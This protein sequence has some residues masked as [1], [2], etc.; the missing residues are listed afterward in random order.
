MPYN[1]NVFQD[2]IYF[3]SF[4]DCSLQL[5]C[6]TSKHATIS[7]VEPST[8]M[9]ESAVSIDHGTPSLIVN[10]KDIRALPKEGKRKTEEKTGNH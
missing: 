6:S 9:S 7:E 10:V 1:Y 2:G 4:I 8:S 3:Y 5:N